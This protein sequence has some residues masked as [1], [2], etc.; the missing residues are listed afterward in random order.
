[1]LLGIFRQFNWLDV[2]IV[3]L[4]LKIIYAAVKNGFIVELFKFL[5]TVFSVYIAFHYFTILSD[6]FMR[7][8]PEEHGFPLEFM[9]YVVCLALL[10][11]V[12][13][14]S[15]FLRSLFCHFVKM[16]AVP[17]LSKWGGLI[18]GIGRGLIAA[19][20]VV[21]MMFVSTTNYLSASAK[22]SYIGRRIFNVSISTYTAVWDGLM[23]KL[24]P[25]EKYNNTVTEIQQSY[26]AEIQ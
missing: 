23:N 22:D 21:F 8:V 19:S 20:L 16:E 12:Y 6:F 1:M 17:T 11:S 24:A 10:V 18:L 26:F 7:R 2:F 14:V 3:F 9:D 5:G 25:K 15:V 4:L 13:L